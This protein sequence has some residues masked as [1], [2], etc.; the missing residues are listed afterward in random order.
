MKRLLGL[1]PW[2]ATALVA[3]LAALNWSAI[4][5]PATLDLL[6]TQIQVPLGAVMLGVT[7]VVAALF[8]VAYLQN[9]IGTLL[10]TRKL[11]KEAQRAHERADR[12][13]AS[14][15]E[16]LKT[17]IT[18]EFTRLN[19]Q[20]DALRSR[21]APAQMPRADESAEPALEKAGDAF[22]PMSLTDIVTGRSH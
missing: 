19:G 11:L 14:R 12:A 13:E 18:D 10:E 4:A 2:I 20:L 5:A 1:L 3:G 21:A 6:V 8:F 16:S 7:V 17:L 9:E 15:I 22:R